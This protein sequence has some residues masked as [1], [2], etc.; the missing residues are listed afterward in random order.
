MT[1]YLRILL[2]VG[3]LLALAVLFLLWRDQKRENGMLEERLL[4]KTEEI[5]RLNRVNDSLE[6]EAWERLADDA[7]IDKLGKEMNRAIDATTPAQQ[8][9]TPSAVSVA[10]GCARLRQAGAT[11][12]TFKRICDAGQGIAG[13]KAPTKR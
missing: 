13:G 3:A 11:S 9:A 4:A 1:T 10:L 5:Q 12:D 2:P 8:A 6:R 7:A